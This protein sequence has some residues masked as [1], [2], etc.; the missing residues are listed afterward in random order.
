M[1]THINARTC[2]YSRGLI[3]KRYQC[4][5]P[6]QAIADALGISRRTVA[7]WIKRWREDSQESLHDRS[8]RPE[9]S[10]K[11]LAQA[12][13]D[14]IV[15]LRKTHL[16]TAFAIARYLGLAY[17]TVCRYLKRYGLSRKRDI[18]PQ[19]KIIR[20]EHSMPGDMIHIDIRVR[21]H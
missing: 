11:Q 8:S 4:G 20:Y 3:I 15:H 7:K 12:C 6:Q 16:M 18:T 17:S 1:N 13:I 21:T 19:P 5:E 10:P 14:A 2:V 9:R